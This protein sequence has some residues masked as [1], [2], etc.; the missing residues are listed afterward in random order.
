MT[1]DLPLT[2]GLWDIPATRYHADPCPQPSLSA[3]LATLLCSAS[4]AHARLAHPRLTPGTVAATCEDFDIGTAAH[5][6]LLEGSAARVVVVDA[7]DWRTKA[8]QEARDVA[9]DA[10]QLPLL[11]STWVDV[12]AMVAA[13]RAQLAVHRDGGAR[14]FTDGHAERTLVWQEDDGTW[15]RARLDW[16]RTTTSGYAV[17]DYKTTRTSANPEQ[18]TRSLYGFGADV[19][20]AWYRR[21]VYK[22]TGVWPTFRFAVQETFAPYALSVISLGP[23]ALLLAEKKILY[24]LDLWRRCLAEDDWPAY[25]SQTC[26][27]TLPPWEEQR[28]IDREVREA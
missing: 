5:A 27:A 12:Q 10:G 9:R 25:P 8:A 16:L 28:W 19:Q 6:L 11:A 24:A 22:L 1:P 14:M 13:V 26:Y 3:S 7:K 2:P 18:W 20:A 4:P 15:C 21:G 23:D 17:D